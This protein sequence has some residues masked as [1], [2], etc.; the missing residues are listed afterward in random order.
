M[1]ALP[2]AW[3]LAAVLFLA[4]PLDARQRVQVL[5][6]EEVREEAARRDLVVKWWQWRRALPTHPEATDILDVRCDVNQ[7]EDVWFLAGDFEEGQ[8]QRSCTIPHGRLIFFPVTTNADHTP[9]GRQA[10]CDAVKARVLDP[11]VSV[12]SEMRLHIDGEDVPDLGRY[13]LSAT[14]CFPMFPSL[15]DY[16]GAPGFATG[17]WIAIRDLPPGEHVIRFYRASPTMG[18]KEMRYFVR[19]E[20]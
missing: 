12:P 17:Y 3:A 16:T 9:R 10:T 5:T 2:S 4:A 20:D 1:I 7:P 19:V 8:K 14:D 15:P 6:P 13:R 11:L 18:Y